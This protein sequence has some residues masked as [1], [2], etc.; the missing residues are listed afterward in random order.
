VTNDLVKR[1]LLQDYITHVRT[2][3]GK[4]NVVVCL[5]SQESRFRQVL[6]G[7]EFSTLPDATVLSVKPVAR[8]CRKKAV[9]S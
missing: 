4:K 6:P 1:R 2:G 3:E 7:V 8:S 9:F 5:E